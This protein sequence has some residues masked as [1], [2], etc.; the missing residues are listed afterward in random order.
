MTAYRVN[1]V[2]PV[3]AAQHLIPLLKEGKQRLLVNVT[4]RMGSIDDNSSGRFAAYRMSKAALNM[5][6]K[7]LSVECPTISCIAYHPGVV[8]TDLLASMIGAN[9]ASANKSPHQA[10]E[11]MLSL[12]YQA[13][14]GSFLSWDGKIIPF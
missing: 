4:S 9:A 12:V 8:A 1:V 7:S 3:I 13:K 2:G 6:N 11:E 5:W 14:S 10:A